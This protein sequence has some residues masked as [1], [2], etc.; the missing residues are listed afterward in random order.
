MFDWLF[1][2]KMGGGKIGISNKFA[3]TFG[4]S[5]ILQVQSELFRGLHMKRV[6][7]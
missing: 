5:D 1:R 4:Y 2:T 3:L 6:Q 7:L